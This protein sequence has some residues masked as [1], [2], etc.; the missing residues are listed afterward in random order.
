VKCRIGTRCGHRTWVT[1]ATSL[2]S[3]YPSKGVL[4]GRPGYPV[5]IRDLHRGRTRAPGPMP[6]RSLG[7][8]VTPQVA[9][10]PPRCQAYALRVANTGPVACIFQPQRA[11]STGALAPALCRAITP[12][13][14][15]PPISDPKLVG[16]ARSLARQAK[17]LPNLL[18]GGTIGTHAYDLPLYLGIT[19]SVFRGA[20]LVTHLFMVRLRDTPES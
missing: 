5:A 3:A 4:W 2:P 18:P 20:V 14:V 15:A 8:L 11:R 17:P 10:R 9:D 19:R 1:I 16:V 12:R 13:I 6:V 7:E